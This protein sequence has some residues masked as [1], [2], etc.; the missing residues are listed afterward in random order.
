[1]A[2]FIAGSEIDTDPTIVIAHPTPM[3][4]TFITYAV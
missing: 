2:S 4:I 1:M 3:W